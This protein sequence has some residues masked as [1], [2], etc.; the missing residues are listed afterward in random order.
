M[1]ASVWTVFLLGQRRLFEAGS[2]WAACFTCRPSDAWAFSHQ[3]FQEQLS[4]AVS[5]TDLTNRWERPTQI[6]IPLR[7]RAVLERK[8]P[9]NLPTYMTV[10]VTHITHLYES[11]CDWVSVCLQFHKASYHQIDSFRFPKSQRKALWDGIPWNV[12]SE[13]QQLGLL[14]TEPM[15][16]CSVACHSKLLPH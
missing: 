12:C 8:D 11:V 2:I 9:H 13:E 10:I 6:A 5:Y 3:A 4:T 15:T 14:F 16:F 1:A 7:G